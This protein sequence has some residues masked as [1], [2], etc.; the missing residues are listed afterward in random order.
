[1]T[2]IT[3]IP[4]APVETLK[5]LCKYLRADLRAAAGVPV[6]VRVGKGSQRGFVHVGIDMDHGRDVRAA[7][8]GVLALDG[9]VEG[10]D[11]KPDPRSCSWTVRVGLMA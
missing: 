11:G 8:A 2:N 6:R 1:M 3:S 7:V 9:W 10:I 4:L 5:A